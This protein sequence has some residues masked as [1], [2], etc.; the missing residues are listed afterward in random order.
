MG[1]PAIEEVTTRMQ[2]LS[3]AQQKNVLDFVR[4]QENKPQT[5]TPPGVPGASWAQFA[6]SISP[7]DL[8]LMEQ[9]LEEDR[10][11]I[12]RTEW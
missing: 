10:E 1:N 8:V 6:G 11:R 7:E 2:A 9:A 4:S 5:T 12:D 3:P